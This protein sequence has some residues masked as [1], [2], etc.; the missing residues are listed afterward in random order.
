MFRLAIDQGVAR[1]TLDRR[2]ARNA[3]AAAQW[4]ALAATIDSAQAA[5]A[6]VLI[7]EGAGGAFCAGADLSDF[8]S[9]KGDL[10]AAGR[11]REAMRDAL[12]RLRDAP[13]PTLA[14]IGG[15]CYGAGV[16]LAMACD[17]RLA[18][19]AASFAI[20]PAKFAISYPQPDVH[21]L[22]SLVGPAQAARL[23]LGAGIIDAAEAERIGLVEMLIDDDLAE[24]A[25]ALA[26]AIAANDAASLATL[27]RG[28][29]LAAAGIAADAEQDRRFD[30]LLAS[31][32]LAGRLR[33]RRR[34]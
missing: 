10:V 27:K 18:G 20:T 7:V 23:L 9:L 11:F 30:A 13:F 26:A 28:L 3:I 4:P 14:A 31:E 15:A 17:L 6:R 33:A 22:V 2:E 19:P 5:G 12:D 24:A 25:G 21:R 32:A 16:A 1:L 8:E 29:S 34:G